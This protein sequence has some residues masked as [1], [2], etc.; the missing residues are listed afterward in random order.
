[1][2]HHPQK[3]LFVFKIVSPLVCLAGLVLM[4]PKVVS[5][6]L[7]FRFSMLFDDFVEMAAS[8]LAQADMMAALMSD[9]LLAADC[10]CALQG[11]FFAAL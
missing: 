2:L 1:M 7:G 5:A 6:R 9:L 10:L 11:I 8:F 4:L 3:L